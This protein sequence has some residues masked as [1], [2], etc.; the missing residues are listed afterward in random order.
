MRY[1]N[2]LLVKT[3]KITFIFRKQKTLVVHI[4]LIYLWFY[5]TIRFY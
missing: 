5:L 4:N 2:F 3:V 1:E